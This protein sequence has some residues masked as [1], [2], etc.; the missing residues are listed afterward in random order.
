MTAFSRMIRV[1]LVATL[2]LAVGFC[3]V[4]R[5]ARAADEDGQLK[6]T[7]HR[8]SLAPPT[9]SEPRPE[10][11]RLPA[12]DF[13]MAEAAPVAPVGPPASVTLPD[14]VPAIQP[15]FPQQPARVAM[16]PRRPAPPPPAWTD[17]LA[18][19]RFYDPSNPESVM[20][21]NILRTPKGTSNR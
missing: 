10:A 14:D 2:L 3:P 19:Q 18:S 5:S 6:W 12:P 4:P 13:T 17:A 11:T 7:P 8:A 9:G 15:A 16:R 1:P 21:F 20:G